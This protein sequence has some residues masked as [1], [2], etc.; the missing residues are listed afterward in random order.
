MIEILLTTA[1]ACDGSQ[2]LIERI[3]KS[4]APNKEELIEV[5]KLNTEPTCYE[6]PELNS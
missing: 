2:D 3:N 5:V 1:L 6:R 4:R